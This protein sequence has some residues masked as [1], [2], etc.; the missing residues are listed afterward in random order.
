MLERIKLFDIVPGDRPWR[1]ESKWNAYFY[2]L[3]ID[4]GN[5]ADFFE[6]RD[7]LI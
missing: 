1:R 2:N 7:F 6:K 4:P 5:L 3:I